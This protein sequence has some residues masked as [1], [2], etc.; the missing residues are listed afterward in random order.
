MKFVRGLLLIFGMQ[1]LA[2]GIIGY[3]TP[4]GLIF[5]A[6]GGLLVSIFNSM[7]DTNE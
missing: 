4:H 5:T 6:I 3:G 2:I 7:V 1:S